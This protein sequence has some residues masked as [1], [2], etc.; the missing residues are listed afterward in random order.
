[1]SLEAR[2]Y[3]PGSIFQL[4]FFGLKITIAGPSFYFVSD[5]L[6]LWARSE[7][8]GYAIRD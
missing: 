8:I 4:D 2:P 3:S 7:A 5:N 6:V 1:M